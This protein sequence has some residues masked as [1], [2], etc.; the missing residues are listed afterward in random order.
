MADDQI[1]VTITAD[2]SDFAAAMQNACSVA[3]ASFSG[4]QQSSAAACAGIDA[5][6]KNAPTNLNKGKQATE[7]WAKSFANLQGA[8]NNSISGMI[9]GTTTWQKAVQRLSQT[10]LSDLLNATEKGVANWLLSEIAKT[11]A[12]EAG[13]AE[14]TA[15]ESAGQSTGIAQMVMSA[16]KA[17]S[18]SAAQAAANTYA[19]VSAIP[20]VGWLLA[21]PAAAA[22]FAAVLAFGSNLPSAAGGLWNVPS[23]MLAMVHKQETI[24]PAGIAQPMRQFFSGGGA[25]GQGGGGGDSYAITVQA[26]DTQSGAQFLMSNAGVIAQGLAREIRNGNAALRGA[27]K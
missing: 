16:L 27:M 2:G 7:D 14:R 8:F 13:V 18:T 17:I 4:L 15:A 11:T 23:D 6:G 24:L 26:I 1:Q 12:T 3:Q 20:Y 22:A 5:C 19:S 25:A 21:P 10:A 9:L